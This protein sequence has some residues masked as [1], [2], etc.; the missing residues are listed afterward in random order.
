MLSGHVVRDALG[1]H[2]VQAVEIRRPRRSRDPDRL[3]SGGRVRRLES[4]RASDDPSGRPPGLERRH[5]RVRARH[6]A[7]AHERWPA[8]PSGAFALADD[9][10]SGARE[11]K[12]SRR[13]R[14]ASPPSV[15]NGPAVDPMRR[16]PSRRCGGCA[17]LA[18][19][20]AFVDTQ[21]DVT[22]RDVELAEREGFRAVEHLKRYTT[23]GM[24]TDQGKTVQRHRPGADGRDHRP[25]DPGDRHHH[26]PP[27]LHAGCDRRAG[28]VMR[29]GRRSARPG[30]RRRIEWARERGAVFVETGPWLRASHYPRAGED[31]LAAATREAAAVRASG[32]HLRRHH[33][34]QDRR[35]GAGRGDFARPAST[36]TPGPT[37]QSGGCATG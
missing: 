35:A 13:R 14:A 11:G 8:P 33:A 7:T 23:L 22:D 20:K 26:Q 36:R 24:A 1:R 27:A 9:L 12:P 34:R 2:G 5:R 4:D 18:S 31:W 21:N 32:R 15:P 30:C 25:L 3:R 10:A 17:A 6:A 16:W 29:G 28:R 19:G 37:S